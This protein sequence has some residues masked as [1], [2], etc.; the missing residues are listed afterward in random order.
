LGDL[1]DTGEFNL[2]VT[3]RLETELAPALRPMSRICAW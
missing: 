2:I 3:P 1:R